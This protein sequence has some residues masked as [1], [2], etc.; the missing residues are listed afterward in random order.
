MDAISA[1][2]NDQGARGKGVLGALTA[3]IDAIS[4]LRYDERSPIRAAFLVLVNSAYMRAVQCWGGVQY[5]SMRDLCM[6]LSV[7]GYQGYAAL[8]SADGLDVLD[9]KLMCQLSQLFAGM[10]C[11]MRYDAQPAIICR[12]S[13]SFVRGS[14][15]CLGGSAQNPADMES[16]IG[17]PSSQE[18]FRVSE[19]VKR[20]RICTY[21]DPLTVDRADVDVMFGLITSMVLPA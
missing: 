3:A 21:G 13:T 14:A 19:A 20:I 18:W 10:M 17:F 4:K 2:V 11:A 8:A 15:S 16:A 1:L 6:M 9:K 5:A 12:D 7:S